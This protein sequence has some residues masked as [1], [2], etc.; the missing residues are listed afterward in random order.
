MH[1][2]KQMSRRYHRLLLAIDKALLESRSAIDTTACLKETYGEDISIFGSSDDGKNQLVS[3]F[4]SIMEKVHDVVKDQTVQ[5]LE[6]ERVPQRLAIVEQIEDRLER[7]QKEKEEMDQQERLKAHQALEQ[8]TALLLS[9]NGNEG[10]LFPKL[11]LQYETY[12]MLKQERD[13]L[14][15]QVTQ[16]AK[17]VEGFEQR[18]ANME[19][20]VQESV[21]T[22]EG[23]VGNEIEQAADACRSS[24]L[25]S[26]ENAMEDR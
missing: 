16:M 3:I 4:D 18:C 11:N 13:D 15:Q 14:L 1:N 21:Q 17:E 12:Q 20:N 25:F 5:A 7:E 26:V 10:T 24:E 23:G 8:Q 9:N 2:N 6:R 19:Q 22:M